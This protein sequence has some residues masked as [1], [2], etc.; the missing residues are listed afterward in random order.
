MIKHHEFER[1]LEVLLENVDA[2]ASTWDKPEQGKAYSLIAYTF[3]LMHDYNKSNVYYELQLSIAKEIKDL[4][5]EADALHGLG[6]NHGRVGDFEK[7]TEYLDQE[8]VAL[9]KLGDIFGQGRV[10][11]VM[12]DVLLAQD[13][14]EK[15][16]IEMFR[17]ASGILETCD[18][19]EG[20]SQVLCQL[21]EAYTRIEAWNDAITALEQS[22]SISASIDF[23]LDRNKRQS[24]AYQVLGQTCLEQ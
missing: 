4:T 14:R 15:E 9:S 1:A 16:A 18:D 8:L 12:G 3:F 22:I 20:L 10:C 5:G 24:Q 7:A 21:G 2:I 19:P 11:S 17:K 13:G 23:E 6:N